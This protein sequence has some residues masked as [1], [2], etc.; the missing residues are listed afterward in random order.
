M[1]CVASFVLHLKYCITCILHLMY[2]IHVSHLCVLFGCRFKKGGRGWVNPTKTS[3]GGSSG[4][5][6]KPEL[7]T[8]DQ[9]GF[10]SEVIF[11]HY[12]E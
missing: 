12:D 5:A 6:G 7:K 1:Q 3:P 2:C 8:I 11:R 10:D 9:V 4:R